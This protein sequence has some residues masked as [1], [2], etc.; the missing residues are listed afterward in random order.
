MIS[1]SRKEKYFELKGEA[2]D[3]LESAREIKFSGA[4]GF[5]RSYGP[6]GDANDQSRR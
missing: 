5:H 1:D 3:Q 4:R 6:P 2:S